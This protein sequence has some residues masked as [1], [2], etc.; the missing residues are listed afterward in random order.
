MRGLSAFTIAVVLGLGPAGA[1][2]AFGTVNTLGQHAEHEKITWMGFPDMEPLTIGQLAGKFG[3][4][5]A[6]GA[7]DR[8]GTWLFFQD[9]SHCDN[10]D[11]LAI[12][13]YPQTKPDARA[14]L[15]ECRAWMLE[16]MSQAVA[17][18]APLAAPDDANTNL[19]CT[20]S[21][22]PS[23]QAG[24]VKCQV[25]RYM[26]LSLHA[27]QDFYSHT[28]WADRSDPSRPISPKNPPGLGNSGRAPWLDLRG[29]AP[30][31]Q[32][33][34]SGCFGELGGKPELL[35]CNYGPKGIFNQ[36]KHAFLN[37]D[38]GAIDQVTGA[39]G[40]GSTD[41]GAVLGNFASAVRAA[42]DDT[43]DKW[44][45]FKERVIA[46]YGPVRG[47]MIICVVRHDDYHVCLLPQTSRLAPQDAAAQ[48]D[49]PASFCSQTERSRYLFRVFYPYRDGLVRAYDQA[50]SD[51]S[52][53]KARY[54]AL[55]AAG[56]ET[57]A[58]ALAAK[59]AWDAAR[60]VEARK[61]ADVK[62]ADALHDRITA[63]RIVPCET[64]R[65]EVATGPAPPTVPPPPLPAG[66]ERPQFER[67]DALAPRRFCTQ[68]ERLA[69][70]VDV[71]DPELAKAS[72]NAVK[73]GE[74]SK[75]LTDAIIAA[76]KDGRRDD[77]A[78]LRAEYEAWTPIAAAAYRTRDALAKAREAI[79]AAPLGCETP[80]APAHGI[81]GT[82]W[83]RPMPVE[84]G[85]NRSVGS[86]ARAR[87]KVVSTALG[88]VGGLL[89]GGGGGG[90]SSDGPSLARCRIKDKEMTVLEDPESG[91]RLKV[92]AKRSGDV[93][94]V[95]ADVDRSPDSGTFQAAYL[96]A[97]AGGLQAPKGVDICKLWGEWKLT[98]SW[99]RSTYVD[100][101]LVSRE[102]GGF[103]D[104]GLFRVPG[105]VSSG[106]RPDGIWKRLGF[107][108][109]SHGARKIA[110]RYRV[111]KGGLDRPVAVVIHV[112]RPGRD[113]V[114]TAPFVMTMREGPEGIA[115]DA[116]Q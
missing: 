39:V 73:A 115:V 60:Q 13:G 20:F 66:F 50:S 62:A 46:T 23:V 1:A 40:A 82:G 33:L 9:K 89:G 49:L 55:A 80:E 112:T 94:T 92:G 59:A 29:H 86:G 91:V 104:S 70:L 69:Y 4:F 78:A 81:A 100:N 61:Q 101:R 110:L 105:L 2:S 27:S 95:Y 111:P 58:D 103:Q 45:Y 67:V 15:E 31:P 10:G 53:A 44:V 102:S 87:D 18:A 47:N 22:F 21:G 43:A 75:G 85:P 74:H 114:D 99:T 116:L 35:H 19:D 71:V 63:I 14:H 76:D 84:V 79:V 93:V 98:V 34:I 64:P 25:L 3:S 88:L 30:F 109:A 6:V 54:E 83:T 51:A 106:E 5:G 108:N 26:G 96:Q 16:T 11:Y 72:A 32:G 65:T 97:G 37:K 12:R 7:P 77:A 28:N 113:P 68:R 57:D 48:P 107:S 41:R 90:G 52:R 36:V 42:I 56:G 8:A 17:L 38:T 24:S